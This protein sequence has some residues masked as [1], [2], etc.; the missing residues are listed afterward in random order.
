MSNMR[1]RHKVGELK[2]RYKQMSEGMHNDALKGTVRYFVQC[3]LEGNDKM[4]N[5]SGLFMSERMA[6]AARVLEER[7]ELMARRHEKKEGVDDG[8]HTTP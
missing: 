8:A 7:A 2:R 5:A 3:V 4:G 6:I 1:K